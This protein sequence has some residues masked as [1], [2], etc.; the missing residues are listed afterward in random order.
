MNSSELP[1]S[2]LLD[3]VRETVTYS[4]L[5][6]DLCGGGIRLLYHLSQGRGP[7][8]SPPRVRSVHVNNE[9]GT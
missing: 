5:P 7:G 2:I 3:D 4:I 1:I 9:T 8:F 6:V